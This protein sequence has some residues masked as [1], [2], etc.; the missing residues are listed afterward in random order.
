VNIA[1]RVQALSG[2]NEIVV[3]DDVLSRPATSKLVSKL[4][5]Q[6]SE[7]RLK[8]VAGDV[9]AHRILSEGIPHAIAN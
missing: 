6:S 9:R 4:H 1:A 7:V 2:A 3:T 8:G 5:I